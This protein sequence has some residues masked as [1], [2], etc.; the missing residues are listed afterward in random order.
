MCRLQGN[1]VCP[2]FFKDLCLETK[3]HKTVK[4]SLSKHTQK[5][6]NESRLVTQVCL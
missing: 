4:E 2:R 3:M 6:S 5:E 1:K